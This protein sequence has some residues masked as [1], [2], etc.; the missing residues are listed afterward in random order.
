MKEREKTSLVQDPNPIRKARR[1]TRKICLSIEW[2]KSRKTR[3]KGFSCWKYRNFRGPSWCQ[4]NLRDSQM[5]NLLKKNPKRKEEKI[6]R[7]QKRKYWEW[8]KKR[9]KE[10]DF[11][12]L[13][14]EFKWECN[15]ILSQRWSKTHNKNNKF[16]KKRLSSK[17]LFQKLQSINKH[18]KKTIN[19]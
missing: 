11:W 9:K 13:Q 8:R 16:L 2:H 10:K 5:N 17:R 4:C 19:A 3:S 7:Y 12:C 6:A 1:R 14:G 15:L 18:C